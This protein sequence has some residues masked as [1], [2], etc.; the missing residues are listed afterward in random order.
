MITSEIPQAELRNF[1]GKICLL[2]GYELIKD[3]IQQQ[4]SSAALSLQNKNFIGVNISRMD[5]EY[6]NN[7]NFLYYIWNINCSENWTSYRTSF[8][9]G[10]EAVIVF[11]SETKIDQIFLYLS[12]LQT[13]F[14]IITIIFCIILENHTQEEIKEILFNNQ[15]FKVK[16]EE[17]NIKF[18]KISNIYDIFNQISETYLIKRESKNL[19]DAFFI[20][21]IHKDKLIKDK[22]L[23]DNCNDY[24][25]P[26]EN[27]IRI[28]KNKRNNVKVLLKFI[29]QIDIDIEIDYDS[30]WISIE[31]EKYGQFLIYLRN[32]RVYLTPKTCLTCK[33]KIKKKCI[34]FQ[35]AP[36][37]ICIE[38]EN[39]GWTNIKGL[40]S[41]ELLVISKIFAIKYNNL[42]K[43]VL[44]QIKK[45]NLCMRM[46]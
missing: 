6:Q 10:A 35:K 28:T 36:Y 20:D 14:P 26:N 31:N 32:G 27:V 7:I 1:R 17:N 33:K 23:S 5:Y 43:T 16:I 38:A 30:E 21:F 4:I 29:K 8:Y 37:F 39:D 45:I 13:L 40:T 42:P 34:K 2:G 11:I 3:Y 15:D 9:K 12:E 25:R 19:F 22:S 41:S 44:D 18:N 24:Y 46:K